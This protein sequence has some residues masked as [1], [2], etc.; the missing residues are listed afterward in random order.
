M[1]GASLMFGKLP[2]KDIRLFIHH[3]LA[4]ISL[5]SICSAEAA[6]TAKIA[7]KA[8]LTVCSVKLSTCLNN[9]RP[10]ILT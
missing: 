6:P 10:A 4:F 9:M 3:F 8:K 1:G 2:A 7:A 5:P